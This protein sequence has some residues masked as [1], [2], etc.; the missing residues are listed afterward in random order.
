M[1]NFEERKKRKNRTGLI[2]IGVVVIALVAVFG[3]IYLDT[4]KFPSTSA[5]TR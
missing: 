1:S 5:R 2:I 4:G 3:G